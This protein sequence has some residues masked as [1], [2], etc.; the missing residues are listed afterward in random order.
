MAAVDDVYETMK[1]FENKLTYFCY[2]SLNR[3]ETSF[4]LADGDKSN[5]REYRNL[6]SLLKEQ[7]TE[8]P[9]ERINLGKLTGSYYFPNSS[10]LQLV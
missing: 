5:E 2:D 4:V 8:P 6:N 7:S 1:I 3:D 10:A 9:Q